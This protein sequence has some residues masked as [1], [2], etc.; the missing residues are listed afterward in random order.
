MNK[1]DIVFNKI[2][3]YGSII[4]ISEDSAIIKFYSLK[5]NRTIKIG[6]FE[7]VEENEIVA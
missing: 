2:F 7:K 4:E 1:D 3:G 5:T 6:F